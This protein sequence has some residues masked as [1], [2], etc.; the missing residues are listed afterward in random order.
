MKLKKGITCL[1]A[2]FHKIVDPHT[3][4][5]ST[6]SVFAVDLSKAFDKVNHSA[7]LVKLVNRNVQVN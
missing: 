4:N 5:G 1:H 7:L 3:V 6:V 2:I